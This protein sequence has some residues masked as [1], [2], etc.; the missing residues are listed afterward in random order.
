M[1]SKKLVRIL[2]FVFLSLIN[3][4]LLSVSAKHPHTYSI[5]DR[6]A[7][8]GIVPF[9][10]SITSSLHFCRRIWDRYFALVGVCEEREQ[11]KRMLAEA[12]ME[13]SRYLESEMEAERLQELLEV[14]SQLPHRL[15]AAQVAAY[16]PSGWSQTIIINKG[17]KD[18][19]A[20][21]MAVIDSEGIVGQVIKDFDW[22]AQVLLLIDQSNAV[23]ALVQRT[24][25]RGI[26]E[27]ENTLT[28][29]FEY[30]VRKADIQI[31]D[32]LISSGL[33][34]VY[35]KGLRIGTVVSVSKPVSGLFQEVKVQP[36]VDFTT[37]E[38]VL[39]VL[40]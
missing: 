35:P 5:L 10:E 11:L 29:R 17:R 4:L 8:A 24:R 22:S 30:V 33:D 12:R 40:E 20:K 15:V 18:G 13:R 39:V 16:D 31:G 19:V 28:C 25:F 36:F 14:K 27:G 34:R 6:A 23:D 32:T 21:G 9:Q 1:F 7:M 37:I 3:I 38:E 2:C 26:V